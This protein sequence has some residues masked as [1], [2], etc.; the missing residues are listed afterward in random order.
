MLDQR[1]GVEPDP[2]AAAGIGE[3]G[4]L[5]RIRSAFLPVSRRGGGDR[6]E[7]PSIWP[8]VRN[9]SAA[10]MACHIMTMPVL[11]EWAHPLHS[12]LPSSLKWSPSRP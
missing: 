11:Y 7:L 10:S 12:E 6:L 4:N 9:P 3:R 2:R 1:L 5:G 8:T